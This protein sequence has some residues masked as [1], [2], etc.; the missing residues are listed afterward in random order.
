MDDS[1]IGRRMHVTISLEL[2]IPIHEPIWNNIM[3]QSLN[4]FLAG[5][6]QSQITK[7]ILKIM[8]G[9]LTKIE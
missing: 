5:I 2:K 3:V 4:N 7:Q 9:E 8:L 1:I 6:I